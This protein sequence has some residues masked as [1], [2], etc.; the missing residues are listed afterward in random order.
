MSPV[1]LPQSPHL[2]RDAPAEVGVDRFFF[3]AVLAFGAMI[4]AYLR[5]L[6]DST[7]ATRACRC[8]AAVIADL[9][10]QCFGEP[11]ATPMAGN[12]PRVG[13]FGHLAQGLVSAIEMA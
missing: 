12:A 2:G 8:G 3:V 9:G 7:I 11:A 5:T 1:V 6:T 10:A 13:P 4:R